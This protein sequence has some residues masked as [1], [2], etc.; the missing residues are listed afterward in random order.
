MKKM[1][2][3]KLLRRIFAVMIAVTL[4]MLDMPVS[5]EGPSDGSEVVEET[6]HS[7]TLSIPFP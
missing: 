2:T 4:I 3:W 5:A 7:D 6:L 1:K